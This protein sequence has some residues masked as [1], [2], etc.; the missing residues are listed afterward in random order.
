[1]LSLDESADGDQVV[2]SVGEE[3]ELVLAENRTA[4]YRWNLVASGTPVCAVV[5]DEFT[6]SGQFPGAS[7]RRQ[8]RFKAI[9]DGTAAI[10]MQYMRA[11]ERAPAAR[12]FSLLVSAST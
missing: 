1:V 11:W 6:P 12:R 3:V 9:K 4:G 8:W 7:G 2:V 5:A 10:E